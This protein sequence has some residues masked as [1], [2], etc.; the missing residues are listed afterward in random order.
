MSRHRPSAM[1]FGPDST[2]YVSNFGF[3]TPPGAG[4]I[5]RVALAAQ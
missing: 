2:L 4:Q 1:A 3:G 5:V